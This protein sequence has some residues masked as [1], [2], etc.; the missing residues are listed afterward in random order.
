M[1]STVDDFILKRG[2][3]IVAPGAEAGFG[4]AAGALPVFAELGIEPV[5]TFDATAAA[6]GVLAHS[7]FEKI[8]TELL[9]SV[10]AAVRA[11]GIDGVFFLSHGAAQT[12]EDNDPEGY[13]FEEV[14]K[15][16][17]PDIPMIGTFDLHVRSHAPCQLLVLSRSSPRDCLLI[18]G[19]VTGKIL[20]ALDALAAQQ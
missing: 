16:V 5:P 14:R 8:A 12:S 11:G 18:Q 3:E 17:G 6:N 10:S 2:P 15:I 1:P 13:L 7:E 4:Y 19:I 9:A 20:R